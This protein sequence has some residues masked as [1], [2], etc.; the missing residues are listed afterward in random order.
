M[1]ISKRNWSVNDLSIAKRF[2]ANSGSLSS[3]FFSSPCLRVSV[4]SLLLVLTASAA[5]F[6]E[7]RA[8][9][10]H[11]VATQ[12]ESAIMSLLAAGLDEGKAV[13]AISEAQKWLR[14]NLPEDAIL[15]YRA[16]RAAE[17]SGDLKGAVALYQQYL[18]RADLATPEADEAVYAVYTLLL[19][20]LHD[21]A[22]AYAFSKNEGDRLLVCPRAKQFD[23]WFLDQAVHGHRNDALAVAN[24][25]RA[26]IEAGLPNDLLLA[27]Y[28]NY[29][30]WL[31]GR[32]SGGTG[33]KRDAQVSQ[34]LLDACKGLAAVITFDAELK[35]R[36]DWA[37]SI[38]FYVQQKLAKAE[39]DAP[40][41]EATALLAKYPSY[42]EEAQ[43]GWAGGTKDNHFNHG[44]DT[45]LYWEHELD[46]KL[47]PIV[48]AAAK[49]TVAERA[50]LFASWQPA[51]YWREPHRL[52]LNEVQ[53]IRDYLKTN[54]ELGLA[55]RYV[56][57]LTKSW[58]KYS[59]E[60]ALAIAPQIQKNRHVDSSLV[61]AIAVGSTK[62]TVKDGDKTRIEY[63]RDFDKMLAAL[64]GPEAWRFTSGNLN[65]HHVADRL[66]H[67]CG[68]PDGSEKRDQAK[69]SLEEFRKK[70]V[71]KGVK[72]DAPANQRIT[73][74]KKL[75]ND[76]NAPQ[77]K[78]PDVSSQ[79][80]KVLQFTPE[81]IPELLKDPSPEAQKLVREAVARGF[82]DAKGP[83][84]HD[85]GANG[86]NP[87]AYSPWINALASRTYGG[88]GRL[89]N[90]KNKYKPHRLEPVLEKA[91]AEGLK[92][93]V[94]EPW[95]VMAWINVQF[96]QN[97]DESV[98]LMQALY[99]SPK[100][101]TLPPEIHY[102]ARQCFK[103][104]AMTDAQAA[105]LD[106][107]DPTLFCQD[108][109]SLTNVADVSTTAAALSKAIEGV[110]A[111]PVKLNIRGLQKLASVTNSVF[112]DP[113]VM[114]QVLEVADGLRFLCDR[115]AE[116]FAARVHAYVTEQNDP[117]LVSRTGAFLW[118][119]GLSEHY[120]RSLP[121]TMT[122][123]QSMLD[124]HP[125]TAASLAKTGLVMLGGRIPEH[126]RNWA[127]RNGGLA[128]LKALFGK[129]AMQLGLVTI[130]VARNHPA[131]P[132]YKSQAEWMTANEDSAWA[133]LNAGD[134]SPNN[135]D[136]L[137]PIHRALSADYLTW[138]LQRTIYSRDDARMEELIKALLAWADETG[139]P[140]SKSQ[141]IDLEIAYGDIAM[142]LGQIENA[143]K[144]FVKTQE[145]PAYVDTVDRHKATL[146]RVRVERIAKRF[147]DAIKTLI[148]LDMEKIPELWSASRYARAEVH[149]DMEEYGAAA[150][151][152]DA[153][154]GRE[155]D[156]SEAKILQGKVQF[157][158]QKLMEASELDVGSP[159]AKNTLVP[160]DNLK[161]TLKD[162]TLAV[163]GA[164]TEI[165]VVVWATSGDKEH[166]LLRQFGDQKTKYRGEVRT[167]LGAPTSDDRVLQVIGDDEI[168]Y[169][170]SERFRK[171]MNNMEEKR[172]GPITV[173]SDAILMAS[174]RKLLS[175]EEQRV[176]DMEAKMAGITKNRRP[177]TA[178]DA[179]AAKVQAAREAVAK[180]RTREDR[181]A[182]EA[183]KQ[184][185][186]TQS[187][188][189]ARV[190]PG[191]P[192]NIRVIDPDRSR[193]A[194]IDELTVSIESSSGDSIGRITL[195]ETGTHTGWFEGSV[196]TAGAQAMAFA[197]NTEPGRN[198]NMVIS[199]TPGYP[200]W[201]PTAT[202]GET[203]EFKIDLNDNVKL[204]E[205]TITAQEP[206]AKLQKFAL[207]T[208]MNARDM[209]TIAAFPKDQITIGKPW[210]PSV[211]IMNDTDH[212]HGRNERSVYDLREIQQ[213]LDRG[214]MTQ[215]Y[216]AG[217]AENVIGPS[218]AMTNSI[219]AKVQ[220][221]RNNHHHNAHVIYRFRGYFYE[222]MAVTR[223]F[224]VEL[225]K[226]TPPEVHGSVANPAQY[227]LAVDGRIITDKEKPEALEGEINLRPGLHRFE[228]WATGWDCRI[229]FGRSV[230]VL[231]NVGRASSPDQGETG[232]DARP[233]GEAGS[234]L[235]E[236]P[237]SFFDPATF[238]QGVLPHRNGKATITPSDDGTAF[239]VAFAA[240][241]RTRLF[242]LVLLAQEGPV[243]ALNT[244]T[245]TEPG[246]DR[247]LPVAEDYAELN[248]NS[249]L[250]ILTGDK[251]A[252]RYVD[253]RFVNKAKEKQ[254]RFL[255][256]SFSDAQFSFVFFEMRK[257]FDGN[258]YVDEPYYERLLR[259]EHGKPLTLRVTDPDMDMTDKPDTV[260][261]VVEST[262][263][264]KKT[265]V[266]KET[267]P[268]TAM[269]RLTVVPVPGAP[270]K[271]NAFQVANGGTVSATYRDMEN[272]APGV[273]V[274]RYT[275]VDHAVF[276]TP[277]LRMA[278]ATVTPLDYKRMRPEQRP[279]R[280]G[281]TIGFATVEERLAV[282]RSAV[283]EAGDGLLSAKI[284]KETSSGGGLILPRWGISSVWADVMSPPSGGIHAVHG[285]E[286]A[287]EIEAPHLALRVGSHV[288]VYVQTD[289][290]R[291][292][293]SLLGGSLDGDM[294]DPAFDIGLPG[295][296]KLTAGLAGGSAMGGFGMRSSFPKIP[297]YSGSGHSGGQSLGTTDGASDT[298][299][300]T[301]MFG[302]R[303]PLIAGFLPEDGV[304]S[305]G[306]IARRRE[307]KLPIPSRE[308][309]VVRPGEKLHVGIRYT[310][311]SGA[312][313]WLTGS[314]KVTTHPALDVMEAGYRD[315]R[316][317]AYVGE[318][319]FVRVVDL[320]GDVSD[321]SDS[322]KVLMQAKSGAKYQVE[323]L[324]VDTHS[325]VFQANVELAYKKS[326][327][328]S[329]EAAAEYSVKREGFPVVYDDTMGVR[330]TDANGVKTDTALL[331]LMKG[332]DGTVWPFSKKYDDPEIAMRT[333]F[334]LA[335]A[336]LEM[337]KRH[338]KL[339]QTELAQL[340]Y[341]R[342]K[343]MLEKAMDM[344][345][346]PDTRAHAEYL[347][348]NLTQEEA[349]TTEDA[350]LKEDRYRAALS[351][352]MRVTGS[353]PNSL[354]ASKAQFKI[355]T[356]YERMNEPEIAAQE[357]VK[358]AYKFPDSEFLA[359]SM[360]RLG[361]HF[362]RKAAAYEKQAKE[363]LAKI[364][365]KD[366]QFDGKA[367]E[368]MYIKEY[369][370]SAEIFSRLQERFP[371]H[372]LAGKGGLR[373]G[374]AYM[375]AG[376][377]RS[378]LNAFKSVF[379]H[380]AYD[381]PKIRAQAMY[382]AGMCYEPL[383]EPM[384]A[385]SI[386]KRLTFDFPESKW[387]SF[388]RSQLSQD[389]LLNIELELEEKRV[390]EGR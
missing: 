106:A 41:A 294:A 135:W 240:G 298:L 292:Q 205:M 101:K 258:V 165:E 128:A 5:T 146:R 373:A 249:T 158:L 93:N 31:L 187:L 164:G 141:K 50:G 6:D 196:P 107:A 334:S 192:I 1:R 2:V 261:V 323:L 322:V 367:M 159:N 11:S 210:H 46:S 245:L 311:A 332:A 119:Y 100:W 17:L 69:K 233:T 174:A 353:Y 226:W 111:S 255:N 87:T 144:I 188:L 337:A 344:F 75:W 80:R 355:A 173:R 39:V 256:V 326:G 321:A 218:V 115:D 131:Y 24:R 18:K 97:S 52:R 213:H 167:A 200:A 369:I 325:G 348:G 266:A 252:V 151:D 55:A 360:A 273:P 79:M 349:D 243:P 32:V 246:G 324:E 312:E 357:Y 121:R 315:T 244:I 116:P 118:S 170:Y 317:K 235:V 172:G 154:L 104:A 212:H 363:L 49:L 224:K 72:A 129:A 346:D 193:T 61:R 296:I 272:I 216:S 330:Y 3:S 204:G 282:R 92:R 316:T 133:L 384:A 134:E 320:G 139:S 130:P 162:P 242:N 4:V 153:I 248:K 378:A 160:G 59:P 182:A 288:A 293:G 362:Q 168:F 376:E 60:E 155:A 263:G 203:P 237:D 268:S 341:A 383:G 291:E 21:S 232:E 126:P 13:L 239:K 267:G 120:A 175:A 25:L 66:W 279:G 366:A 28:D 171:K 381:G 68:R 227:L 342:A 286:M 84:G 199:P 222:P 387:A 377:N 368:A 38:R 388:A 197:R 278:H 161:V 283:A 277:K 181:E 333:Q 88:M 37:V 147:D 44:G 260:E 259:F 19:D 301:K 247:V 40:I 202:S 8:A 264:G 156:H 48:A 103:R 36:L 180:G 257:K 20:R 371:D 281:L 386:Y 142:Q 211:T 331:K 56:S 254:E 310:D 183:S 169:A 64:R 231:A 96:P 280:R 318:S 140:W 215:Q 189:R 364:D 67:Y 241:S 354:H 390:E 179:A 16:G 23:K 195:K 305:E 270:S 361:T 15:L 152:I 389:R 290:G 122:L 327:K 45:G 374:Q 53:A 91:V 228:I 385:Y 223:R 30:R 253:D 236:C 186:L 57:P 73:E 209:T 380:E 262:R 372:E 105:W 33:F 295:T 351:R 54:P 123:A 29:F 109:I 329:A 370:R 338:R 319:L 89:K 51:G 10:S 42:A 275:S 138:V 124:E 379:E 137:L 276:S 150:D 238:P 208:G 345:R 287:F 201:R 382:W 207:Q 251:V 284:T 358:L 22:G 12:P 230:K 214:W 78:V 356:V 206:G 43:L 85:G 149:Y 274:D 65:A 271:A 7:Q 217:L 125:A 35:L 177:A 63:G 350:E 83:F 184:A 71:Y 136:E 98:K 225:G 108:L 190:K 185:K 191:A 221:K 229:G 220:W 297:I 198:P 178:A 26:C 113:R 303:I 102:G 308:A 340:E 304:L 62:K 347:L 74:F 352:Y 90:D 299:R 148:Q 47:A 219:P 132:I 145:N 365:D 163:S 328:V 27:R 289:A 34:E 157:K 143:H 339:K 314:A 176:A 14:Q 250:E 81:V 307:K 269:F 58:E 302:C 300:S 9:I 70:L 234:G 306:E 265:F 285:Q 336:Y 194:A 359:L 166:F 82:E 117:V 375:R 112:I 313:Q 86:L 343:D 114:D 110:K 95:L 77:P 99:K 127:E 94:L 335:E 309:L 76:Y